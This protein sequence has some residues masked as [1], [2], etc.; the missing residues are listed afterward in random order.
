MKKKQRNCAFDVCV[1]EE[2]VTRFDLTYRGVFLHLICYRSELWKSGKK[3]FLRKMIEIR[4]FSLK[5][6][7]FYYEQSI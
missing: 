4:C 3:L 2:Y 1:F 6:G 7:T 5:N